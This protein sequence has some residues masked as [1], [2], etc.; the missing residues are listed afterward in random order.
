MKRSKY[1]RSGLKHVR[2]GLKESGRVVSKSEKALNISGC[3]KNQEGSH[4]SQGES[5]PCREGS[6]IH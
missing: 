2:K 3:V 5:Q 6:Q 4:I 1:V